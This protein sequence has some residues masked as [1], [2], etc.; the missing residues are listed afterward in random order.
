MEHTWW[1]W[2]AV[3]GTANWNMGH[4]AGTLRK[5][6]T[7]F[8]LRNNWHID[9]PWNIS[10]YLIE[11]LFFCSTHDFYIEL[12]DILYSI[13]WKLVY[14]IGTYIVQ[15]FDMKLWKLL[16]T[17]LAFIWDPASALVKL[18]MYQVIS[19]TDTWF[20]S[21]MLKYVLFLFL[22][23]VDDTMFMGIQWKESGTESV[24]IF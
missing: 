21:E 13:F 7:Y 20:C 10:K 18:R 8:I 2:H 1:N 6:G 14:L 23:L 12:Y 5:I 17:A 19:L 9:A 11:Y 22:A 15:G 16:S 4:T 3:P 24:P